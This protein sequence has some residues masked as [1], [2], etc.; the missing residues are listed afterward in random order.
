MPDPIMSVSDDFAVVVAAGDLRSTDETAVRFPHRWTA[1]GVTVEATFTG[2]H[3]LHLAAAG[4]ILNDL[5]R[6]AVGL[7]IDLAGV[8][9]VATGG[10]DTGT[11]ASTGIS[12]R[13]RLNTS[14]TPDEQARLM[15]LV[16][17]VA[18]I[19]RAIRRGAPVRRDS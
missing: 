17:D 15:A 1:E 16:D 8:R 18:E 4:C 11:W 9:V 10:F 14:A 13:I 5:Y 3:L 6:E 19:P 2:A 7:G 12:Y